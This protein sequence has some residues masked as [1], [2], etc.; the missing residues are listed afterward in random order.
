MQ[1]ER[2]SY[3]YIEGETGIPFDQI[4]EP[5]KTKGK[6]LG[7]IR[8]GSGA[9]LE[10]TIGSGL[11]TVRDVG[12]PDR[13]MSAKVES[14]IATFNVQTR[15]SELDKLDDNPEGAHPDMF[16][17]KFVAFTLQQFHGNNID[18]VACQGTW[19]PGSSNRELF[20]RS[21]DEHGDLVRAAKETWSGRLFVSLGFTELKEEDI[22]VAETESSEL[23]FSAVFRKPS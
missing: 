21:L 17:A 7:H 15:R 14:G 10:Y 16:A 20:M 23:G 11:I 13:F 19:V 9:T 3:P 4:I 6:Q 5:Y 22:A 2:A 8:S 18:V 1:T 12:Y